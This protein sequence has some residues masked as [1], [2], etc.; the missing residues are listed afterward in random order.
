MAEAAITVDPYTTAISEAGEKP[1]H[2]SP[3]TRYHEEYR[4]LLRESKRQAVLAYMQDSRSI[5]RRFENMLQTAYQRLELH[6]YPKSVP[7]PE[8]AGDMIEVMQ[9]LEDQNNNNNNTEPAI[10]AV[11]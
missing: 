3:R 5:L 9:E 6:T 10:E 1:A 2:S 4:Q 11:A 8:I 7:H